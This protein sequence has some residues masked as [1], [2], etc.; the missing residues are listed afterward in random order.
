[1]HYSLIFLKLVLFV[2]VPGHKNKEILLAKGNLK[3]WSHAHFFVV[4]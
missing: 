3:V 2:V 1:M 4:Y